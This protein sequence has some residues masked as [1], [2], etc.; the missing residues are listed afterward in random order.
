MLLA[1]S[2]TLD[3]INEK[4][5]FYRSFITIAFPSIRLNLTL[6]PAV[7]C[8][9]GAIRGIWLSFDHFSDYCSSY[10]IPYEPIHNMNIIRATKCEWKK[11]Q[12]LEEVA[13][14]HTNKNPMRHGPNEG[15]VPFDSYEST[16]T[17][18]VDVDHLYMEYT[19][20]IIRNV[21]EAQCVKSMNLKEFEINMR[22]F[23]IIGGIF[24]LDY[25]EQPEQC[26]KLASNMYLKTGN[27]KK[28]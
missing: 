25:F 23:R 17:P 27:E 9:K 28:K 19:N 18:I 7:K 21:R 6:P 26:V 4:F 15:T 20:D 2:S 8:K 22:Q 12:E 11:R 1:F 14:S 13:R 10:R 5:A 16:Q 3:R 24:C